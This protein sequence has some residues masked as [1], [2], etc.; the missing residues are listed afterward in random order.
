[1][2]KSGQSE[3][4]GEKKINK[5]TRIKINSTTYLAFVVLLRVALAPLHTYNSRPASSKNT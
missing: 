4:E 3:D 5:H 2:P 1:M